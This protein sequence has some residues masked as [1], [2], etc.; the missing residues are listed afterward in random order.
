LQNTTEILTGKIIE[1]MAPHLLIITIFLQNISTF[2]AFYP[3]FGSVFISRQL[4]YPII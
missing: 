1:K 2:L 3:F 4:Y